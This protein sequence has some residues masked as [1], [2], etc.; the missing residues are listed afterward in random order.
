MPKSMIDKFYPNFAIGL[1]I[2]PSSVGAINEMK[3]EWNTKFGNPFIPW[4]G[5]RL[6]Y[7]IHSKH[8]ELSR[9]I[10]SQIESKYTAFEMKLDAPFITPERNGVQQVYFYLSS[11]PSFAGLVDELGKH[12]D[13]LQLETFQTPG[14][15]VVFPQKPKDSRHWSISRLHRPVVLVYNGQ[16]DAAEQVFGELQKMHLTSMK[17]LSAIGLNLWYNPREV[18]GE[19]QSSAPEYSAF[20]FGKSQ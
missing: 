8:L 14:N 4:R 2:D 1:L 17:P 12:F 11:P 3:R 19:D 16:H 6:I 5:I 18:T 20:Y 13:P 15:K 7:A 10:L 9:D